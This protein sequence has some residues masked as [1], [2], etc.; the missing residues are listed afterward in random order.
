MPPIPYTAPASPPAT[1]ATVSV[2]PPRST[3]RRSTSANDVPR[4]SAHTAWPSVGHTAPL[5]MPGSGVQSGARTAAY[6]SRCSSAT[7]SSAVGT[8][9]SGS[10]PSSATRTSSWKTAQPSPAAGSPWVSAEMRR[11]A[12]AVAPRPSRA[13]RMA[14]GVVRISEPLP[15]ARPVRRKCS[16]AAVSQGR[17]EPRTA[18]VWS[19]MSGGP[20]SAQRRKRPNRSASSSPPRSTR[21]VA[22]S[23][24]ICV[25]SVNSPGSRPSAPP[26]H[27]SVCAPRAGAGK[28]AENCPGGPNSKGAP[29]A[30]P[31]AEPTSA[32]AARCERCMRGVTRASCTRPDPWRSCPGSGAPAHALRHRARES[33]GSVLQ[34]TGV[35][36]P[37]PPGSGRVGAGP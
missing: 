22:T 30:S 12:S 24:A 14:A 23:S 9:A 31:T 5:G 13:N 2:S 36:A 18:R 7:A 15:A 29:S 1:A 21:D 34:T 26:P 27:I 3:T 8:A 20:A 11:A 16:A 19:P 35:P 4:R 32:P 17:P 37:V 25:S 28:R 10:P 33:P 6:R